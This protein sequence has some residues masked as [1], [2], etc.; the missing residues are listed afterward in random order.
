[1]ARLLCV[2]DDASVGELIGSFFGMHGFEVTNVENGNDMRAAIAAGGVD[3]ILLD[4]G[5]PGEDGLDLARQL[6]ASSNIPL[7]IVSG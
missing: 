7:L 4:L 3:V 1:M 5:L 2:D 6:R